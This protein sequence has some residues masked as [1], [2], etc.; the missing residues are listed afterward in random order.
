VSN[1]SDTSH[2]PGGCDPDVPMENF[3][4]QLSFL[5]KRPNYLA[6]WSFF[7]FQCPILSPLLSHNTCKCKDLSLLSSI[8]R[9]KDCKTS[10]RSPRW[11]FSNIVYAI[12]ISFILLVNQQPFVSYFI[13]SYNN[14]ELRLLG[15]GGTWWEMRQKIWA[16]FETLL[17][18]SRRH[19][20]PLALHWF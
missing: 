13:H 15:L 9:R 11:I 16:Q 12:H 7:L 1:R 20:P 19:K 5:I 6:C 8:W 17:R 4:S 3:N 14:T 2:P 18:S 10:P